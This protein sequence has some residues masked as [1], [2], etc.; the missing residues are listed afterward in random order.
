MENN[1]LLK[2]FKCPS[3]GAGLS[4][5]DIIYS[6]EVYD[7]FFVD[8]ENNL[9]TVDFGDT[10]NSEILRYECRECNSTLPDYIVDILEEFYHN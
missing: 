1:N 3:C 5:V 6:Q 8:I 7:R 9:L 10:I 2:D 4:H